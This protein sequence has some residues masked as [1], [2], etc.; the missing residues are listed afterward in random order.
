MI[1]LEEA[2]EKFKNLAPEVVLTIDSNWAA[3]KITALEK[4]YQI[5]LAPLIV[6]WAIGEVKVDQI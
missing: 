1:Y 3:E 6:Y 2:L 4:K 5:S